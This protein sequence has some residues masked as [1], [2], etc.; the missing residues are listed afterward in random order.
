MVSEAIIEAKNVDTIY[1]V[2]EYFDKQ[3][4]LKLI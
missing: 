2:P 3:N 4:L 1:M